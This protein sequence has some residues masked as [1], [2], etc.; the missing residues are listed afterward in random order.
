MMISVA[1]TVFAHI[2]NNH[3]HRRVIVEASSKNLTIVRMYSQ[4]WPLYVLRT[5]NKKQSI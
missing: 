1:M 4:C 3:K 2:M 5:D